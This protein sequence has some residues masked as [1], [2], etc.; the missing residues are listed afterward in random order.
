MA[1]GELQIAINETGYIDKP[2]RKQYRLFWGV[3]AQFCYVGAQV[4]IAG[5]F[6]NYVIEVRPGTT[7]SMGANQLAIAQGLFAIGRFVAGFSMKVVKPRFVL[8]VFMSM[9]I[10]FI[11]AAIGCHGST[12]IAMLSLVLFFESCIFPTIFTLSLRGLGR[13]TKRGAS[14]IVSSV[15]GGAVFP[16]MLGAVADL[17]GTR[18]AMA[19][20]LAGF[21]IAWS[22]PVYLNVFCAKELDGYRDATVGIEDDA[23]SQ[24]GPGYAEAEKK[25]QAEQLEVVPTRE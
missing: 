1:D 7:S 12:G 5:Y 17:R 14:F 8:M 22:F 10:V 18:I 4:A 6:V 21:L 19:V 25:L 15:C 24:T 20:P 23:E 13:H 9:I 11:A 16:P 3:I 2:L